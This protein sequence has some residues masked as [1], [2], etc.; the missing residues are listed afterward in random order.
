MG[1]GLQIL[2]YLISLFGTTPGTQKSKLLL[3]GF[4]LCHPKILFL[5]RG[6]LLVFFSNLQQSLASHQCYTNTTKFK[7]FYVTL[8]WL[9][10]SMHNILWWL[11]LFMSNTS[12]FALNGMSSSLSGCLTPD[13]Q[14]AATMDTDL[15][16]S[17]RIN[18]PVIVLRIEEARSSSKL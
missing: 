8:H 6:H 1:I 12:W 5:H 11:T 18:N 7:I 3:F 15:G 14:R 13:Y 2:E 10:I 4:S 17:G 16:C 9:Y